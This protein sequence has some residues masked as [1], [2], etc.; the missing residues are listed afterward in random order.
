MPLSGTLNSSYQ[1]N[2]C[3]CQTDLNG[4]EIFHTAVYQWKTIFLNSYICLNKL[5]KNNECTVEIHLLIKKMKCETSKQINLKMCK[6]CI[7][8]FPLI[9][10]EKISFYQIC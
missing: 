9:R 6:A 1:L 4:I 5:P 8:F 7:L 3:N 2:G 10:V